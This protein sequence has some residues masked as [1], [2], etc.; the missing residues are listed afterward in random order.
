MSE[1][2]TIV[3]YFMAIVFAVKRHRDGDTKGFY[4][5]I[6]FILFN[7]VLEFFTDFTLIYINFYTTY[8]N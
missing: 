2:F 6:A 4:G 7:V 8:Q 3:L 1:L 5:W